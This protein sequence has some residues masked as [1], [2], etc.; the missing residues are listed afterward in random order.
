MPPRQRLREARNPRRQ[1]PAL[2]L[3]EG[4][5]GGGGGTRGVQEGGGVEAGVQRAGGRAGLVRWRSATPLIGSKDQSWASREAW[6]Q[7]KQ[8]PPLSS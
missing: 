7:S 2:N 4:G 8:P 1:N 3:A 6:A 5:R